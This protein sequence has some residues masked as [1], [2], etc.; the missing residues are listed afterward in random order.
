MNKA[1]AELS[2]IQEVPQP[3]LEKVASSAS[4]AFTMASQPPPSPRE[5]KLAES[6][7]LSQQ[8]LNEVS[9]R[10]RANIE[11][12]PPQ[13]VLAAA[14]QEFDTI[15]TTCEQKM[16]ES[17]SGTSDLVIPAIYQISVLASIH[18]RAAEG[19]FA[20]YKD[21]ETK[22]PQEESLGTASQTPL[23]TNGQPP[24]S[25]EASGMQP[26]RPRRT[27]PVLKP[28]QQPQRTFAMSN[29]VQIQP[30]ASMSTSNTGKRKLPPPV[31]DIRASGLNGSTPSMSG[32]ETPNKRASLVSSRLSMWAP[33]K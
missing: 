30:R 12:M 31:V 11:R 8:E 32:A 3:L 1:L 7:R 2:D 6:L 13:A 26:P 18:G 33:S 5:I 14:A 24:L 29:H 20:E 16:G 22:Q 4:A 10:I 21:R 17:A 9:R 25:V 15:K 23:S 19:L 28:L 27:P